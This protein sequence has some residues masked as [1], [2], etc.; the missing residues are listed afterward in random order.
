[1]ATYI[2]ADIE[3][4]TTA[5]G[6]DWLQN[7]ISQQQGPEAQ[8]A[9]VEKFRGLEEE[10]EGSRQYD[11]GPVFDLFVEHCEDLFAAIPEIRGEDRVKDVESFFAL[12][13]SMLLMLRETEKLD[14]ATSRLCEILM[15]KID[16]QPDLRLRLLMMLYNTFSPRVELRY[17]IFKHVLDYA[18]KANLFDQ[19][20]P[21]LEFLDA[22]MVDWDHPNHPYVTL[23]DKKALHHD[24]ATYMRAMGKRVDAFLHIKRYHQLFQGAGGDPVKD[25]KVFDSAVELLTD[26]V[27]IA[28]VIQFDDILNFDTVK[29]L[30][31]TKEKDLVD[32]C[33]I[34]FKGSVKDLRDFHTKNEALFK[35]HN[36]DIQD[37]MSKIRL[38]TLATVA[39]HRSEITLAEVAQKLEESEDNVE[40]WVV[41]A[42]SEGVIDGRIDQLNHK[43]IVKSAF[44]RKFEKE[45]W[46]FLDSKLTQ[47]IDN[48]ENVI[49]FIG[50]QK[51]AREAAK[52]IAAA[53]AEATP[54]TA[55]KT[56]AAVKTH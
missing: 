9:F 32:L 22:W 53:G 34:F 51:G 15:S 10:N 23:D 2:P 4:D 49:K 44:Q 6:A 7:I 48:L 14:Q 5:Q 50:E 8:K 31:K 42:I 24:I 37:A 30:S 3:V 55:V 45:E 18:H 13:F 40:R 54:A 20:L 16:Q 35:R 29:A 52:E 19:V 56:A 17:R 38:L 46:Q 1:M 43:V 12:V 47:W 39:S 36:L 27:S 28:S 33:V 11:Y 41:R 21:Y 25:E 26:A